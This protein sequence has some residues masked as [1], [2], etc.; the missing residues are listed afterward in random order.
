M[1]DAAL[2]DDA[3]WD[4]I[5]AAHGVEEEHRIAALME[6]AARENP[7]LPA[8]VADEL[9]RGEGDPRWQDALVLVTERVLF[10]SADQRSRVAA[11]LR[12]HALSLQ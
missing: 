4:R 12:K 7:D 8:F 6:L 11:S 2:T 1:S 10:P 5:D 9:E 3:L